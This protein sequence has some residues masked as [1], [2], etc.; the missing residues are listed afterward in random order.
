VT[1]DDWVD[2]RLAAVHGNP[3]ADRIFY[4]ASW[5]GDD[6]RGW[7]AASLLRS[8][9]HPQPWRAF[10]RQMAWLGIESALVNGPAK[11]VVRRPRPT[12]PRV[13]R[14]RLRRP[15]N[16]SFPSGHAASAA[17]MAMLLSED[18]LAPL[19]WTIAGA[20][21]VSRIYVGVHHASDV[22]AGLA[23]GTAIGWAARRIRL[24]LDPTEPAA[25]AGPTEPS[26][27][28]SSR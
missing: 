4:G 1:V 20:V 22:A 28:L 15:T 8:R 11:G 27:A 17:T 16:S 13:H 9:R 19:W 10:G 12:H 7:I 14:H 24:P 3:V 21:A 18:G 26:E 6:G 23:A 5:F 25:A 2:A